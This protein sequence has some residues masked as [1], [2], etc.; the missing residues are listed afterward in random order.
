MATDKYKSLRT[1]VK[2]VR[3]GIKSQYPKCDK[4]AICS[5]END[6]EFHHYNSVTLLVSNFI[7][8]N[9]LEVPKDQEETF[10]L[11]ERIYEEHRYELVEDTVT[12]CHEHHVK[13][14]KLYGDVPPPN[15]VSKQR[16]WVR[17]MNHKLSGYV[18]KEESPLSRFRL[19]R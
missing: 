14:H 17:K 18:E 5:S 13:L 11:R 16:E 7:E 3:D 9:N 1:F 10:Q 8:K 2:S 19:K 6:L 12:L 4:C 15:T